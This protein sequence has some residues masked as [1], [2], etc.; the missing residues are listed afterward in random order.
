M[1]E[2]PVI[3]ALE[4]ALADTY[5]LYFK[6]HSF[7]WNV[8]GPHFKAL[9]DLFEVQYTEMWAA[10]DELAERIRILGAPAPSSYAALVAPATL[11]EATGALDAAEMVATLA[12]ENRAIVATLYK[13]LRAAQEAEDE[14]TIALL[15]A[16]I[17]V[18]EKAAWMLE[19]S[20]AQ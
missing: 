10:I 9:H 13:A 7:H 6:T 1:N 3:K 5:I 8:T 17:E 20:A 19:A 11:R 4:A 14:G 16:R 15:T 18:H 12:A 2:S